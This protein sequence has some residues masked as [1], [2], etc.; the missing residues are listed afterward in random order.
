MDVHGPFSSQLQTGGT[1]VRLREVFFGPR[2]VLRLKDADHKVALLDEEVKIGNRAAV[3][4][5]VAGPI[6][7]HKMYFDNETHLLLKSSGVN[8]R[9]VTYSNYKTFDGIPVAL[10]EDDGY[11]LPEII[12][13]QPVDAFDPKLFKEP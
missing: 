4:V 7:N 8:F 6:Y 3:A 9:E 5:H 2:Q 10:K 13:F 1:L 12:A 11:F